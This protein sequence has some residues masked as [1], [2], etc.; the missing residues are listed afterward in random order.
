MTKEGARYLWI[1][2]PVAIL[3]MPQ[4]NL[5]RWHHHPV[6]MILW[7]IAWAASLFAI[8]GLR[9][10]VRSADFNVSSAYAKVNRC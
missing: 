5:A 10:G 7:T 3:L 4:W 8:Y 2:L 6:W 1:S 9:I